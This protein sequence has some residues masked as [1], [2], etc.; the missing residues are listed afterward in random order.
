MATISTKHIAQAIYDASFDKEGAA[1][2]GIL[3]Q[4]VEMLSA[5]HLLSRAP[6]IL[7]SLQDICDEKD[8]I[9]RA[10]IENAHPLSKKMRSDIEDELKKRYNADTII[11]EEKEDKGLIGGIRIRI[12]DEIIDLSLRHKLDLLQTHLITH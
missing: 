3:A 12:H 7:Q 1:L 2:D 11:I 5:K 10:T 8:G 9:V 6:D 4:T